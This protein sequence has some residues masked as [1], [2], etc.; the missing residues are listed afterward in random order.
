[1]EKVEASDRLNV[2]LSQLRQDRGCQ[3]LE[4]QKVE[5]QN[6]DIGKVEFLIPNS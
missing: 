4:V 5:V 1:M 3:K 6:I 2:L